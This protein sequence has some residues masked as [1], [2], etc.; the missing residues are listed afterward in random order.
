M[1]R[2]KPARKTFIV[3]YSDSIIYAEKIQGLYKC[4]Y[5]NALFY[6]PKD[7]FHHIVAHAKGTLNAQREPA[8]RWR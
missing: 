6:T 1:R 5:C 3:E 7:L 4:P 8:S 2:D